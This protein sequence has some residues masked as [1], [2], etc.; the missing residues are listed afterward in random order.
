MR[1]KKTSCAITAHTTLGLLATI[2]LTTGFSQPAYLILVEKHPMI[3]HLALRLMLTS[4]SICMES[5]I[6][7]ISVRIF[8][9]PKK[10][11]K[12]T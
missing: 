7:K 11:Q 6:I 2:L 5:P 10:V 4:Q 9:A 3:I 12:A 1:R 8:M